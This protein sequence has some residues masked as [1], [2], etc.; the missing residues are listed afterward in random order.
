[1]SI[2]TIEKTAFETR[3]QF[4]I[5]SIDKQLLIDLYRNY[6]NV[7]DTVRFV[8][9]ASDFFPNGN[10]GLASLYLKNKL[11]GEIVQ[12]RYEE[13]NHTFL[14]IDKTVIDVTAD[15]FGGPKVYIGPLKSPWGL[16]GKLVN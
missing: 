2:S 16:K 10:C 13:H 6:A 8:N 15:Q 7:G 9:R 1:M 12:G 3:K 14:I 11:G 5:G 4:E